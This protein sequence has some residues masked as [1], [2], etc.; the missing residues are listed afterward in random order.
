MVD[1]E[2][3]RL[4]RVAVRGARTEEGP[5]RRRTSVDETNAPLESGRGAEPRVLVAEGLQDCGVHSPAQ[6]SL[7]TPTPLSSPL[8][9]GPLSRKVFSSLPRL[10]LRVGDD[11]GMCVGSERRVWGKRPQRPEVLRGPKRYGL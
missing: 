1:I 5:G 6:G 9:I 8:S 4:G 11:G 2:S 3:E 7:E 10:E